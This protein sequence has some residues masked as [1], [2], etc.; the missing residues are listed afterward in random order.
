MPDWLQG[1]LDDPLG[2]IERIAV[3]VFGLVAG[4]AVLVANLQTIIDFFKGLRGNGDPQGSVELKPNPDPSPPKSEDEIEAGVFAGRLTTDQAEW[5]LRR[6]QEKRAQSG[7]APISE[8]TAE[9]FVK[10]AVEIGD[11]GDQIE[12]EAL[13]LLAEG[14]TDEAARRY[15]S[16]VQQAA[17]QAIE[18]LRRKGALFAPVETYVAKDRKSVV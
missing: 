11:E 15:E 6:L 18:K 5:L 2:S 17:G 10:T 4:L 1:F 13:A 8:D 12:K 9:A 16:D 7:E 3:I 14:K